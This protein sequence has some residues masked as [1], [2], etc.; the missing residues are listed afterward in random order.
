[1]DSDA[2]WDIFLKSGKISDY[3]RYRALLLAETAR[4]LTPTEGQDAAEDGRRGDPRKGDGG[5]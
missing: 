4:E 1:M 5:E 2:L 3:L